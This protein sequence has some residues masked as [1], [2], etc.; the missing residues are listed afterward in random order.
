MNCFGWCQTKLLKLWVP[1][2]SSSL[3]SKMAYRMC[4]EWVCATR[5]FSEG[6]KLFGAT[7]FPL[8][9]R[10]MVN[11]F[12]LVERTSIFYEV[13][14]NAGFFSFSWN[15]VLLRTESCCCTNKSLMCK[16]VRSLCMLQWSIGTH[17]NGDPTTRWSFDID[18]TVVHWMM[19]TDTRPRCTP[20]TEKKSK[21]SLLWAQFWS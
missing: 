4:W 7:H 5:G 11:W 12:S 1:L 9:K 17:V 8:G 14:R 6:G 15:R 3:S 10:K 21:S 2:L 13:D 18:L 19:G 20:W 16:K